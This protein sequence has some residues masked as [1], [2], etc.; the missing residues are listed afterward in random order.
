ME[1]K[2]HTEIYRARD[3]VMA[4]FHSQAF[5]TTIISCTDIEL[6]NKLFAESMAYINR[7][8][9]VPYHHPGSPKLAKAVSERI[10]DC[11]AIILSN[12]GAI[13]VG[14]GTEDVLLRTE[15]LEML[16]RMI[17]FSRIGDIELNFLPKHVRDGFLEHL[18][19]M[20]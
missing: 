13:C 3:D 9:R 4:V 20:K 8:G 2:M 7:I 6:D 12:H 15:T 11:D 17:V 18:R 1:T 5:Y 14:E 16:C 10:I 19:D